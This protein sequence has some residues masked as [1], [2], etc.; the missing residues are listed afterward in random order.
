VVA[1]DDLQDND[2]GVFAANTELWMKSNDSSS[3]AGPNIGSNQ[4]KWIRSDKITRRKLKD[5]A[6]IKSNN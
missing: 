4:K 5:S 3:S 2:L 6:E 1:D